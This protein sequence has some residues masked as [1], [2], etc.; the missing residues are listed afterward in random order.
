MFASSSWNEAAHDRLV[1]ILKMKISETLKHVN[2]H[3]E[4]D[5][6]HSHQVALSKVGGAMMKATSAPKSLKKALVFHHTS[7]RNC[8]FI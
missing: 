4:G 7:I 2:F 6:L 3:R 8:K 5:H 1:V